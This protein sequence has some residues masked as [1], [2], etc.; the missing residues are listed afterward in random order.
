M[1]IEKNERFYFGYFVAFGTYY[2][3]RWAHWARLYRQPE[4]KVEIPE[5]DIRLDLSVL[6]D[7]YP[8]SEI[9]KLL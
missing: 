8:F 2:C 1:E 9:G 4:C 3:M 6:E 5:E 7:R